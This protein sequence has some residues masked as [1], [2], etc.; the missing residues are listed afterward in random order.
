MV[1]VTLL[2]GYLGAGKTTLQRE[3]DSVNELLANVGG[4]KNNV[5]PLGLENEMEV[6]DYVSPKGGNTSSIENQ[7]IALKD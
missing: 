7:M 2:T 4:R 5:D 3:I 1:P 6:I